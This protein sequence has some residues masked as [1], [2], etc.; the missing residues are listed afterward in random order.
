[1]VPL[2]RRSLFTG[3]NYGKDATF[4]TTEQLYNVF[5]VRIMIKLHADCP[6]VRCR[7]PKV[8][9]HLQKRHVS[10]EKTELWLIG[11]RSRF[12]PVGR[13]FVPASDYSNRLLGSGCGPPENTRD[14]K[15]KLPCLVETKQKLMSQAQHYLAGAKC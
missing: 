8:G 14:I 2:W 10:T 4:V 6:P 11:S 13:Q 9:K 7:C 15:P 3:R 12:A 5:K 1:M